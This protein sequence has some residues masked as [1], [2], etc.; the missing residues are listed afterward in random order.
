ME[1]H[2]LASLTPTVRLRGQR[3]P[4][5]PDAKR[6]NEFLIRRESGCIRFAPWQARSEV[7]AGDLLRSALASAPGSP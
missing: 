6:S 4:C 5:I 2:R 7:D 1:Q 3:A